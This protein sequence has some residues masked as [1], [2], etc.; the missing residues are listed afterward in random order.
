MNKSS[1]FASRLFASAFILIIS[2]NAYAADSDIESELFGSSSQ[3][4]DDSKDKKNSA[5][6]ADNKQNNKDKKAESDVEG[7]F[8]QQ[9]TTDEHIV[10]KLGNA[11]KILTFGGMLYLNMSYAVK[12]ETD[13]D[14]DPIASPNLIDGFADI[15]PNDRLRG[16]IRGRLNYDFTANES[17]A[18]QFGASKDKLYGSLDQLWLKADVGRAVFITFG[19]QPV[20]WG[21]GYFWNPT[22]FLNKSRKDPLA[23]FDARLG[24]DMLKIHVPVEKYGWNF[25]AMTTMENADKPSNIG[26]AGRAEFAFW[27]ME[28]S[29]M[30][31]WKKNDA[32]YLGADVTMG[33][34][35]FDFKAEASVAHNSQTVFYKGMPDYTKIDLNGVIGS[36]GSINYDLLNQRI[37][38]LIPSYTRKDDWIPQLLGGVEISIPYGDDDTLILGGEYFYNDAGYSNADVLPLLYMSGQYKPLYVGR[39]YA[40]LYAMLAAPYRLDDWTFIGSVFGNL[41]DLSFTAHLET[42]VTVLTYLQLSGYANYHFGRNGEL[43]YG[44]KIPKTDVP[45]VDLSRLDLPSAAVNGVDAP[46][47]IVEIGIGASLTF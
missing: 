20:K 7:G 10:N 21:S 4:A 26:V 43:Y 36:D 39:H 3:P 5:T 22:D 25:Y 11:D 30:A 24:L 29:F 15:R 33:V 2:F 40:G 28:T 6:G 42:R 12:K 14:D 41:S 9:L 44:L 19:R 35:W 34:G 13:A 45:G 8:G 16:F 23:R 17:A 31:A 27:Q 1:L 46:Q 18:A 32:L 37:A 38:A 47:T